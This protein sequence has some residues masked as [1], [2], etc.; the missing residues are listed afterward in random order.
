MTWNNFFKNV[1]FTN[2]TS[3]YQNLKYF[4]QNWTKAM[5]FQTIS[6]NDSGR[7][8]MFPSSRAEWNWHKTKHFF[9]ILLKVY[10]ISKNK[11]TYFCVG[12]SFRLLRMNGLTR[13]QFLMSKGCLMS[14]FLS[15]KCNKWWQLCDNIIR[16]NLN[17]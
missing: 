10:K 6:R 3:V 14:H 9:Q 13:L 4:D 2:P 1:S 7:S 15:N 16:A 8:L 5:H 12:S 11:F 17:F